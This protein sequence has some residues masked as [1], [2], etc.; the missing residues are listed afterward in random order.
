M[1]KLSKKNLWSSILNLLKPQFFEKF[2][3]DFQKQI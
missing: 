3:A 2:D 1:K